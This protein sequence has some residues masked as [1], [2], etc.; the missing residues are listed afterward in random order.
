VGGAPSRCPIR[1]HPAIN[2]ATNAVRPYFKQKVKR[3][4][5]INQYLYLRKRL[6]VTPATAI[7]PKS[8]DYSCF[9]FRFVVFRRIGSGGFFADYKAIEE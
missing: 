5:Y 6:Y 8:A 9:V 4:G 3:V 7:E 2:S 1:F